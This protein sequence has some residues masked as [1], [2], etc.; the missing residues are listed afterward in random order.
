VP[1]DGSAR[2]EKVLGPAVALGA[3][4]DAEYVLARVV[5][6]VPITGLDLAGYAPG[7][8]DLA[9]MDRRKQE[10]RDYLEGVAAKLRERS[11]QVRTAVPVHRHAAVGIHETAEAEGADLIALATRG[12]GGLKRLLLG[13][14]ADKVIRGA[15]VPVFVFRPLVT[16]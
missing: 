14:V 5:A 16:E 11:L 13:S 12:H 7:G 10:A 2:A 15:D 3:L 6:P 1:L 9:E 8:L 4:W